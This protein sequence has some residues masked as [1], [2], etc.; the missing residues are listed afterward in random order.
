[1]LIST[2]L[3]P[4]MCSSMS[5]SESL[6]PL[7]PTCSVSRCVLLSPCR[8]SEP[9]ISQLVPAD[10]AVVAGSVTDLFSLPSAQKYELTATTITISTTIPAISAIRRP[11]RPGWPQNR[12]RRPPPPSPPG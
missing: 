8:L 9:T 2:G 6:E 5:E 3:G 4:P 1:M 10:A 7:D 11:R 12:H